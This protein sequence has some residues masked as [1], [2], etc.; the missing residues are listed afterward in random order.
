[1]RG[2]RRM[3]VALAL[4][5]SIDAARTQARAMTEALLAGVSLE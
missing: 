4:G 3:G 2:H 1:V 5:D